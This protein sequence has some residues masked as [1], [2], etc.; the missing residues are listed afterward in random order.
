[1]EEEVE[2]FRFGLSLRSSLNKKL[3]V[4]GDFC[5]LIIEGVFSFI[6]LYF[7]VSDALLTSLDS[8]LR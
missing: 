5:D 7:G 4:W 8:N 6:N 2:S 3:L 1:M